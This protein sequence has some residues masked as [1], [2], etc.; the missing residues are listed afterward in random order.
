MQAHVPA[1]RLKVVQ[2]RRATAPIQRTKLA[3]TTTPVSR[4]PHVE[5]LRHDVILDA[6]RRQH[7]LGNTTTG[8]IR[9]I[10]LQP[11]LINAEIRPRLDA[12]RLAARWRHAAAQSARVA[13]ER[14]MRKRKL[15]L[16]L[17]LLGS[18][19]RA[20]VHSVLTTRHAHN[21]QSSLKRLIQ[22]L[23]PAD[24]SQRI[25]TRRFLNFWRRIPFY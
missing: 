3:T 7:G 4:H 5:I 15:R 14:I 8:A 17:H 18:D 16:R 10:V 6:V 19:Q 22:L 12:L 13:V 9:H 11:V 20:L 25:C 21:A 24:G 1:M 2:N 23:N